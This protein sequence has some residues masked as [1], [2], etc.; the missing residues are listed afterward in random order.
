V[1]NAP[2]TFTATVSP[3]ETSVPITYT[4][5]ATGQTAVYTTTSILTDT[6]SF[7]WAVGGTK[8]IT[9]TADNGVETA[10]FTTHTIDI[11]T[12]AN[13][14]SIDGA[15]A[16]VINAP[17]TFTAT[18]SPPETSVPIT[19]TWEATGQTAVYT[20]TSILTDTVSFSWAVGGTKTITVTA[21]NGVETAVFTTHT[22]D[23]ATPANNISIDGAT[24]GVINA[25][26]TFTAT[27]SPPETSVPITYTWEATG[28]TA[29]Y[30]TTS[31]LTDTV[32]FS[33]AVG[34]TKMIT[35]TATNAAGSVIDTHPIIIDSTRWIYLPVIA[36]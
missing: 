9:V 27:V 21:D 36:R 18:V 11:A 5:E 15:T 7:S 28:Q 22:I 1:I 6:V 29:V 19:Y 14:I 33:W 25:P 13:N 31:I 23:I 12:P 2:Y 8:T 24:A 17:Y 20:T 3:P 34:G 35:V 10:V 32:S 26:Y 30:T 16:G 4:W